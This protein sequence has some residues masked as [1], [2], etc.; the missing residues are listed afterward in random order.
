MN[1]EPVVDIAVEPRAENAEDF[2]VNHEPIPAEPNIPATTP[3]QEQLLRIW[4][5]V[6]GA[7]AIGIDDS[8][9]DLGGQSQLAVELAVAIENQ[10]GVEVPVGAIFE[11]PTIE[12][13]A[14]HLAKKPTAD[15]PLVRLN[16]DGTQPPLFFV[17]GLFKL[18]LHLGQD[19]PFYGLT[20]AL[21]QRTA[22]GQRT[23]EEMAARCIGAIE[24]A[25]RHGPYYLGGYSLGGPVAFEIASQLHA[26]G[27][28]IA[29][30]ALIDPDPPRASWADAIRRQ[31]DR[32][33]FHARLV[34]FR[35][36][37]REK[38][39]HFAEWLARRKQQHPRTARATYELARTAA[40]E[41]MDALSGCYRA[42]DA[43]CPVALFVAKGSYKPRKPIFDRRLDWRKTAKRGIEIFE[44]PG[45][46]DMLSH[47]PQLRAI[48]QV[49]RASLSKPPK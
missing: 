31:I 22:N 13:L 25:Q 9:F 17:H 44:I 5:E 48:A 16:S 1:G 24:T 12:K 35:L 38:F 20:L 39:A 40:D 19:Q 2:A 6:L 46:H 32:C 21:P 27:E 23:I 3:L 36:P 14:R 8:F 15:T 49:L 26:R 18:A 7:G 42:P 4:E 30:L 41:K 28:K 43:P 37:L 10:C 47:E 33:A 29:L 34:L 45:E 11:F